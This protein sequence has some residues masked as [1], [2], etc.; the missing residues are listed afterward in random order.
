MRLAPLTLALLTLANLAN[1]QRPS[2]DAFEVA[3]IKPTPL[4]W[5]GGRI[6]RMTSPQRLE[7][8]NYS[9]RDLI[10]AAFSLTPRA[11]IGGPAWLDSEHYDIQAITAADIEPNVDERM[12]M[13][14]QLLA[15]R[16]HLTF[17][18]E[19]REF[20]VYVLSVARNGPKLKESASPPTAAPDLVNHL[21]RTDGVSLPAR[22]ATMAQFA[23]MMQ[24]SIFDRPVVDRTALTARYDFDLEW[25]PDETQF[26][27]ALKEIT[28]S[29]KPGFLTALQ[30]Q[31]G[32]RLESTKGPVLAMV[33]DRID[34]PSEN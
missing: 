18:R 14:R 25:N 20:P 26:S 4:D 27:G 11:V 30:E 10:A 19:E 13:I 6:I 34:H 21:S 1:A 33:I 9:I 15:D 22:N 5:T 32:L 8:L 17:H 23:A 3:T 29:P 12:R 7:A 16:L 31:L 2:F 28:N 24:R